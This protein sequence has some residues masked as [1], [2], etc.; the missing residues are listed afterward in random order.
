MSSSKRLTAFRNHPVYPALITGVGFVLALYTVVKMFFEPTFLESL[1][2]FK[3]F[4]NISNLLIMVI[5]GLFLVGLKD[6]P[7]FKY[8]ALIG[9]VNILMTGII[10]H[11]L[12]NGISN[13]TTI[14]V[15]SHIKH[16]VNPIIYPVFYYLLV[17]P[18]VKLKEFWVSLVFPLIYFV[19]FMIFGQQIEPPY[20]FMNPYAEGNT[21][22]SV[23]V[24]C[25][26]VLLPVIA[27]FTVGLVS[28]KS[29][30]E[31]KEEE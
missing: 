13:F 11:L 12:V 6:K 30:V 19:F 20:K 21:M 8:L 24:F 16:T 27:L 7:W 1:E 22:V 25:L 23:L 17:T 18:G 3:Y 4:T 9:L 14:S 15:D 28:L 31:K 2:N 26:L 5:F 10:F 29:V